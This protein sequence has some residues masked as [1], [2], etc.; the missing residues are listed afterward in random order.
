MQV[1]VFQAKQG[2][3][4]AL[5]VL[6]DITLITFKEDHLYP[7]FNFCRSQAELEAE[8]EDA[9]FGGPTKLLLFGVRIALGHRD[10]GGGLHLNAFVVVLVVDEEGAA[11]WRRT[12]QLQHDDF[13]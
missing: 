13:K 1:L 3:I 4:L 2:L 8:A 11:V 9:R 10:G 5:P 6:E 7:V 12:A